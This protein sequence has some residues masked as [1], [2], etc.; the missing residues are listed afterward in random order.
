[1]LLGELEQN[2]GYFHF[3]T[4]QYT[5]IILMHIP[6]YSLCKIVVQER[7]DIDTVLK[8]QDRANPVCTSV[9]N[10]IMNMGELCVYVGAFISPKSNCM[11]QIP[12]IPIYFR[13]TVAI[14]SYTKSPVRVYSNIRYS[15]LHKHHKEQKHFP[16]GSL[17]ALN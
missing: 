5:Y 15:T 4:T 9:F 12:E 10:I 17:H 6:V 13:Q 2:T 16:F 11:Q 8:F 1:M 14:C 3:L 7:L